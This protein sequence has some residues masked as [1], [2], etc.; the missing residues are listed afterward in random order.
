MTLLRTLADVEVLGAQRERLLHGVVLVRQGGAREVE[1]HLVRSSLLLLSCLKSDP[2][3][4]VIPGQQ[5]D[6]RASVVCNLPTQ[7]S[8]PELRETVRI[9]GVEA[10]R[11][12]VRGHPVQHLPSAGS[13]GLRRSECG[14]DSYEV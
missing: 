6:H 7:D 14:A 10:E 4:G 1:V 2:E 13:S 5:C 12:E 9:V 11:D 3:P 8:G